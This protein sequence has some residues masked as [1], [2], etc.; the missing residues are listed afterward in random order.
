MKTAIVT[1][2]LI[3]VLAGIGLWIVLD[4]SCTP[5]PD[6]EGGIHRACMVA[7]PG[8][9]IVVVEDPECVTK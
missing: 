9:P 4:D 2:G 7:R 8:T 6:P 3:L 1:V 5:M